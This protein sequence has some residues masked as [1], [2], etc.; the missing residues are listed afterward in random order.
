MTDTFQ[1]QGEFAPAE[2]FT[3][4]IS[5]QDNA[6]VTSVSTE[7]ATAET[8]EQPNGFVELGLA[9]ELVQAVADL[10]YTQP[11]TV[12]EKAIP[13]AMGAGAEGGRFIDLMVSSQTGSGKTA[14]FLLP[15]LHT[16]IRQ[17]AEAEAESRAEFERAV[18]EAAANGEAPPKRAKRKDPTNNRN[19]KP[20]VPGALIVC[21]T[22][23]LAQQVAHDAIDLVKHA[24]GLRVANVVGG[25]P[26]QLQWRDAELAAEGIA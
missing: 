14:A 13:L 10:G 11:T 22:R 1:V 7:E 12:Q 4:D 5:V 19:F 2:S 9:P 6:A 20:A 18:A 24:R 26:Y 3:A 21:P 25:M 17:Q 8:T 15:V 16:L 23:E